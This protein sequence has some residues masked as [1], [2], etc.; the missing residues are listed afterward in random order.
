[1]NTLLAGMKNAANYGLTE[2]NGIKHNTT[3]SGLLDLFAMGAA[4]RNRTEADCILLFK[5]AYEENPEYAMK[6]LFYIRDVKAQGERR[7]FRIVMKWLAQNH[8]EAARRNLKYIADFGRV[9][10]L[11]CFV[12]TP[13]EEEMFSLL[14]QYVEEA[15][16][17]YND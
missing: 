17:I 12:D 10:D 6:C 8:T 7:F 15:I 1:M 11:Y 13:L 2:N 5:N 14:K 16:Q 3:M 4:M 9:D